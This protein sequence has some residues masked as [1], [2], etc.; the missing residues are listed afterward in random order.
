[1]SLV[2]NSAAR[3]S[4][5][6]RGNAPP[7]PFLTLLTLVDPDV[8]LTPDAPFCPPVLAS[9]PLA[10]TL[11]LDPCVVDL[12]HSGAGGRPLD[13]RFRDR[14]PARVPA[15]LV[16]PE[17]LHEAGEADLVSQGQAP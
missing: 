7:G 16:T 4:R 10:F 11:D 13:P 12:W 1:M 15:R 2:V 6:R 8:D 5:V 3:I 9:V 17:Q 14:D